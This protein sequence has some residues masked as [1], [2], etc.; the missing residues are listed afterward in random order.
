MKNK[1][2]VRCGATID[3]HKQNGWQNL[4]SVTHLSINSKK[5]FPGAT[6]SPRHNS[7]QGPSKVLTVLQHKFE[8]TRLL[9]RFCHEC[10]KWVGEPDHQIAHTR[11]H[12]KG[13]DQGQE[14]RMADKMQGKWHPRKNETKLTCATRGPPESPWQASMP[15]LPAQ[16][17][18]A[19]SAVE[20]IINTVQSQVVKF[21]I[22]CA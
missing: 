13:D 16:I 9:V 1:G 10:S 14:R 12:S 22:F 11:Q 3:G 15:S 20:S 8:V 4:A 18:L 6:N 5:S 2:R 17:M 21:H 7:H 19:E